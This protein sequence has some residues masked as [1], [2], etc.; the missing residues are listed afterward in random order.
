MPQAAV[1]NRSKKASLLDPRRRWHVET[2]TDLGNATH[3][4]PER[5]RSL[6]PRR[7][8]ARVDVFEEAPYD[9]GCT[10]GMLNKTSNQMRSPK[11]RPHAWGKRVPICDLDVANMAAGIV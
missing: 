9:I 6:A 2:A 10:V 5:H 1:S 4:G 7:C 11:A 3:V 8:R